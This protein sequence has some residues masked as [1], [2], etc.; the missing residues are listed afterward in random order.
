M[1]IDASLHSHRRRRGEA[2]ARWSGNGNRLVEVSHR[3]AKSILEGLYV[4][5]D[6][7]GHRDVCHFS[8][9]ESAYSDA[10]TQCYDNPLTILTI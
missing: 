8:V 1:R 6:T 10:F 9:L 7:G 3:E 4:L 5:L 2:L